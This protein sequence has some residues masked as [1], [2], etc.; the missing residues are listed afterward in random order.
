MDAL[1][2]RQEQ[3]EDTRSGVSRRQTV[4]APTVVLYEVT[5]SYFEGECH[6]LAACGYNRDKKAGK[7]QIVMGL[8]TT[9]TGAPSAVHV[10]DGHTSDPLTGPTPVEKLSTRVGLTEVVFVEERGLVKSPGKTVRAAAGY[11]YITALTT[12]RGRTLL[13]EGVLRPE[14]LTPH[15]HEVQHG[16]VRLVLRRSEAVRRR[17]DTR[18]KLHTLITARSACVRTAKRAQPDAGLRTLHAWVT[19]SKL[20]GWV[21]WSWQ[22]GDIIATVNEAAQTEASR[23][24]GCDV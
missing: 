7:L 13:R 23:F 10:F 22:E 15:V 21:P 5:S 1:A 24:D 19:R 11:Q 18:A 2:P 16:P 12:P 3:I 6:A 17:D 8:V 9:G 4:P 14:W 20:A